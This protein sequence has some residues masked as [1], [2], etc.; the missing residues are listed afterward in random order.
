MIHPVIF[1]LMSGS[2][3]FKINPD[4]LI[5]SINNKMS[6][7]KI[8]NIEVNFNKYEW[9]G[10][11]KINNWTSVPESNFILPFNKNTL[12]FY[13]HIWQFNEPSKAQ[14]SY[15]LEGF[16]DEWTP[17]T[18][19]TKAVFTNLTDN[20]Y[21]LRIRGKLTSS[22]GK[23]TEITYAFHIMPPWYR[24]W[25]F[26]IM[27]F[28]IVSTFIFLFLRNRFRAIRRKSEIDRR[29]SE[30]K[31]EALKSQMNPHFIFNA[32][33]SIQKYILQKDTR[34]ALDYMSEFA[35]LIR[36]TL[37]NSTKNLISLSD[38][39]KYLT[40]YIDLEKRRVLNL[41]YVIKLAADIDPQEIFLP[42]MLIQP[43]VENSIIH[44][45]RHLEKEGKII[46]R[47][48]FSEEDSSYMHC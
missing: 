17:Y 13:Y 32:F 21:L 9:S 16:Q 4:E 33:N 28:L 22:P 34:A 14:Y 25:W 30:L 42:P 47:F 29:I 6:N 18:T 38:E 40:S 19:E 12:T 2:N 3:L 41:G 10:T 20:K 31:M 23:I 48:N 11:I 43:F 15:K 5:N 39:I 46:I 35:L 27:T 44:G 26:Y 24:T 45:I 37:D 7:L 36:Q 1:W 8:D